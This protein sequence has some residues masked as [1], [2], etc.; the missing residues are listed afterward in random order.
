MGAKVSV[1]TALSMLMGVYVSLICWMS[2]CLLSQS[3]WIVADNPTS[4]IPPLPG[5]DPGYIIAESSSGLANRL[6]VMAAYMYLAEFKYG[7][8][9][10][11]FIW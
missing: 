6:R 11:V 2:L 9:H 3:P 5:P 1:R 10:L 7:G 8:A 4:I